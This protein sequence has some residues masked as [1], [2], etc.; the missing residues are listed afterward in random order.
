M[1]IVLRGPKGRALKVNRSLSDMI[2]ELKADCP[3]IQIYLHVSLI[4][5]A[6]Q[7]ML[8]ASDRI[9]PLGTDQEL[10][11]TWLGQSI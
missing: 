11:E 8:Y 5:L 4:W 7:Y 9:Y 3:K 2:I 6:D 10:P 1:R